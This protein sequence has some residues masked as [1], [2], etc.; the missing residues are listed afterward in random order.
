M[1][2]QQH[3]MSSGPRAMECME[4]E[5]VC[6]D[7]WRHE[8]KGVGSFEKKSLNI[9]NLGIITRVSR[10]GYKLQASGQHIE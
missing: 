2:K 5:G 3:S 7:K 6:A 4:L 1:V 10:I 9:Q 8:L